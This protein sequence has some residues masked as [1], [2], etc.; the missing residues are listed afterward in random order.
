MFMGNSVFASQ[1]LELAVRD[2]IVIDGYTFS[3]LQ[4]D[5]DGVLLETREGSTIYTFSLNRHTAEI[6]I[7][8]A[9]RNLFG[10]SST[11]DTYKL[12]VNDYIDYCAAG[13]FE[14]LTLIDIASGQSYDLDLLDNPD[15]ISPNAVFLIPI[16]IPLLHAALMALLAAGAAIIIGGVIFTLAESIAQE[17]RRQNQFRYYAAVLR[18]NQVWIGGGLSS[19]QALSRA[20]TNDRVNGVMATSESFARGL[21]SPN[22][23]GPENH[24]AGSGFWSHYHLGRRPNERHA[25][26]W[27]L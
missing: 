15:Q 23:T 21:V 3:I 16:G 18:S 6:G 13:D 24:G 1:N 7:S 27:F 14:G 2:S 11:A 9:E 8:V 25:H 10:R 12:T 19:S 5:V 4:S 20:N 17:L 26:V 22:F